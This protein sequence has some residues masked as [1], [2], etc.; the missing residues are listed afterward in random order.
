MMY[1][2]PILFVI[3]ICSCL[4]ASINAQSES[5]NIYAVKNFEKSFPSN[6]TK[7]YSY[8]NLYM[9]S[10]SEGTLKSGKLGLTTDEIFG[11]VMIY[12]F[13][14]FNIQLVIT[15]DSTLY[16]KKNKTGQNVNEKMSSIHINENTMFISFV[17]ANNN[18]VTILSDF[19]NGKTSAFFYKDDAS[20][21]SFSGS[22]IMKK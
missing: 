13:G 20:V 10:Y 2:N 14:N 6:I 19:E 17:D 7:W 8:E 9:D 22:I 12:E 1:K 4:S 15:S 3:L 16:L 21:T 18:F 11:K 5:V